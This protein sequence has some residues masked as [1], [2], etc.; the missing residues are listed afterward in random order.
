M[1]NCH[2]R[3]NKLYK[4]DNFRYKIANMKGNKSHIYRHHIKIQLSFYQWPG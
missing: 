3:N 2:R 1:S 4:F